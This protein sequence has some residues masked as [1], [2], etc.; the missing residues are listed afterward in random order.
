MIAVPTSSVCTSV[1]SPVVFMR[2]RLTLFV[3]ALAALLAAAT[4]PLASAFGQTTDTTSADTTRSGDWL[5]LPYASYEPKTRIAAGMVAGYYRPDRPG[6]IPSS[7][8][9]VLTVTQERQVVVQVTP[10][11]Y[12]DNGRHRVAGEGTVSRFPDV[13]FGIGG[14]TPSEREEDFTSRYLT[15]EA[16][17]QRRIGAGFPGALQVGPRV[18][19]RA[20]SVTEVE[21][22]GRLATDAVAGADGGFTAGLGAGLLWEDRDNIYYPRNGHYAEAAALWHS[23]VIGSDF[24]F[25]RLTTDFRVYRSAGPVV[26]AGNVYVENVVGTPP[27][28]I[29]P[30]LGG[31]ERMRGY[32]EGRYRDRVYWTTQAEVRTP[33]F[34]RFGATAFA[35]AGDVG[36]RVGPDLAKQI[37]WAAGLGGRF[38]LN[39]EGVQSRMDLAYGAHGLELYLSLLEAF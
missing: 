8:Q 3:T 30:L 36:P 18:Y 35:S 38:R 13:F 31:D 6:R 11:I 10:E 16:T 7:V 37:H 9:S 24:T 34:W 12:L 20:E 1:P 19:M 32:R 39:D 28:Q 22:D 29:L 23:A 4:V 27:F 33:L 26:F 17:V 15:L 2:R 25:A 5:V 21:A 14:D